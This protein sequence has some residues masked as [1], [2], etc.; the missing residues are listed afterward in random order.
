MENR[1]N[2]FFLKFF[3]V[4]ITER[5]DKTMIGMIRWSLAKTGVDDRFAR[6]KNRHKEGGFPFTP[7]YADGIIQTHLNYNEE[8]SLISRPT[9]LLFQ[10]HPDGPVRKPQYPQE[11]W[12]W[13]SARTSL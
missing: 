8:F 9:G 5:C 13:S 11:P 1:Q 7:P 2:V 10:V 3:S 12:E 6:Q 4:I